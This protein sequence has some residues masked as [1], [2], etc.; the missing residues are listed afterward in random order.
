MK[1]IALFLVSAATLLLASCSKEVTGVSLDASEVTVEVG[2]EWHL[3]AMVMPEKAK[4]QAV[5]WSVAPE[6]IVS[7]QQDGTIV[8]LKPGK[9]VVTATTVEGGFTDECTVIVNGVAVDQSS[10]VFQVGDVANFNVACV[11]AYELTCTPDDIVALTQNED[12]SWTA[13]AKS[14]KTGVVTVEVKAENGETAQMS[15][16]VLPE[17]FVRMKP[18]ST[19]S[20]DALLAG[21]K[22]IEYFSNRSVQ[23]SYTVKSEGMTEVIPTTFTQEGENAKVSLGR[24][25]DSAGK[26]KD[27]VITLKVVDEHGFEAELD[28]TSRAWTLTLFWLDSGATGDDQYVEVGDPSK[29]YYEDGGKLALALKA[30]DGSYYKYLTWIAQARLSAN[31]KKIENSDNIW[32]DGYYTFRYKADLIPVDN[33]YAHLYVNSGIADK[34]ITV[35]VGTYSQTLDFK[36]N[37]PR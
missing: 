23:W 14:D 33:V 25:T 13:S 29:F 17:L 28:V 35:T 2:Q 5:A 19:L 8:G 22:D 32:Q 9:A 27:C 18:I 1:R 7:L 11:S 6:G 20:E 31:I 15:I 26:D 30:Q 24:Y 12:G 3:T 34:N 10:L 37:N 21:C 4:N 36:D 16:E